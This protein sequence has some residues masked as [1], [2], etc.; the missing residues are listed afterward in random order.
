MRHAWTDLE[1]L[2]LGAPRQRQAYAAL[3]ALAIFDRLADFR[4][5]LAGTLP[6]PIYTDASDLDVLCEVHDPDA[7]LA[8]AS[9]YRD[10]DDFAVARLSVRGVPSILVRFTAAGFDV[11]LFGQPI[12][13][14]AQ[15]GW[16]HLQIEARVL[17]LA[18]AP[19]I[20]AITRWKREGLKTEPAFARWLGLP[21][22]D[23]Y[24]ALLELEGLGD[25]ELRALACRGPQDG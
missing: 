19:A 9:A 20:D 22:D 11:E 13:V 16:R 17:D 21:G 5:A 23:P 12:P 15:H 8:A 25:D 6:L 24:L 14:V 2:R 7:F 10:A 18:G 4:P 1:R 3:Q